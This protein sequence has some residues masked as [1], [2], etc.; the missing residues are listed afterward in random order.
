MSLRLLCACAAAAALLTA[1]AAAA[2]PPDLPLDWKVF[3]ATPQSGEGP[4]CPCCPP[5]SPQAP[6]AVVSPADPVYPFPLPGAPPGAGGG[7][8]A[9]EACLPFGVNPVPKAPFAHGCL[10]YP[11]P[12]HVPG[13]ATFSRSA[14]FALSPFTLFLRPD[15]FLDYPPGRR[16]AVLRFDGREIGSAEGFVVF[17]G[18]FRLADTVQRWWQYVSA[19]AAEEAETP[20]Q[21]PA[22][23]VGEINPGRFLNGPLPSVDVE[24]DLDFPVACPPSNAQPVTPPGDSTCPYLIYKGQFKPA[25]FVEELPGDVIEN[26]ENLK[27]AARLYRK[28]ERLSQ[29]GR[30][31]EARAC[32]EKIGRV[33]RGCRY[34]HLARESL[35][36]MAAP[37]TPPVSDAAEEQEPAADRAALVAELLAACHRA[38]ADGHFRAAR[39]LA[40]R[41]LAL[42]PAAV[43]A[44]P[45]VYRTHLLEQVKPQGKADVVP[46]IMPRAADESPAKSA[47]EKAIEGRLLSPVNLNFSETPLHQV[48]DDLRDWQNINIVPDLKALNDEG[49]RIDRPVTL[50]LENVSLKSA[51]SLLFGQVGLTYVIK[52]E[53][54]VVTT[55]PA[56]LRMKSRPADPAE[57]NDKGCGSAPAEVPA[58]MPPAGDSPEARRQQKALEALRQSETFF[59]AGLYR[60]AELYALLAHA[61]DPDNP[62]TAIS[63]HLAQAQRYLVLPRDQPSTRVVTPVPTVVLQPALPPVDYRLIEALSRVLNEGGKPGLSVV[64]EG[65]SGAE[66]QEAPPISVRPAAVPP[67]YV[68]PA[69][70]GFRVEGGEECERGALFTPSWEKHGDLLRAAV[71]AVC[72][73]ACVDVKNSACGGCRVRCQV[74]LGPV[75]FR[76]C[77]D[78]NGHGSFSVSVSAT[79]TVD[80]GKE[81]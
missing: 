70:G 44:D 46:P 8:T 51:L 52:D 5:P 30:H 34:D 22:A 39:E 69:R 26:L 48:I 50:K 10:V 28:A 41:A 72:G 17:A 43:A 74:P 55:K 60:E 58:V 68:E 59:K 38:A 75:Q 67:L 66:E 80:G 78:E 62:L 36:R 45:L 32:Y 42:D 25:G 29:E 76:L 3:C 53:A 1:R 73:D 12:E 23:R 15:L 81:R 33:C 31:A 19:S 27:K 56:A 37:A 63:L 79:L 4:H 24:I 71:A 7:F 14:L 20:P 47:V 61:L 54:L 35:A 64:V 18:P 16:G 49:I 21:Q 9:G 13:M 11:E 65:P 77:C 57:G 2:K 6:R 40:S